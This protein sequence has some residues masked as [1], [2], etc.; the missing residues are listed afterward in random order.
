MTSH[1]KTILVIPKS[2]IHNEITYIEE[3]EHYLFFVDALPVL[4]PAK[5][6][7]EGA[8]LPVRVKNGFAV[9]PRHGWI[10]DIKCMTYANPPGLPHIESNL[11]AKL[12][13]DNIYICGNLGGEPVDKTSVVYEYSNNFMHD[14]D[15][16]QVEYINHACAVFCTSNVSFVTDP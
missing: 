15:L 4:A 11:I 7:H 14:K 6:R 1:K 5:C 13:D 2:S 12:V 9:C 8:P 16:L 3:I 10:L